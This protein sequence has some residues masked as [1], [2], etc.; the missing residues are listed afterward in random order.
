MKVRPADPFV[1][2]EIDAAPIWSADDPRLEPIFL[3]GPLW[4]EFD[5]S[6]RREPD[7]LPWL[8]DTRLVVEFVDVAPLDPARA[9]F[10]LEAARSPR[11]SAA[12]SA[13]G[14]GGSLAVHLLVFAV[15][16]SR[17]SAPAETGA[18]IPVQLVVEAPKA[19]APPPEAPPA[20]VPQT[21]P[22]EQ[23]SAVAAPPRPPTPAAAPQPKR[24]PPKSAPP[25][26]AAASPPQRRLLP[27]Q[28]TEPAVL[29]PGPDL[30]RTDYFAQLV[31]L[32][33]PHLGLLPPSFLAG[34]RGTTTLA[35][36]VDSDGTIERIAIKRSS[37]YPD[38]DTQIERVIVAVGRFPPLPPAYDGR[39]VELDFDL[40]F[41]DAMNGQ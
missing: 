18:P 14:F 38:I 5:D 1:E 35:I 24:A 37:G 9:D 3:P 40:R 25:R 22:P 20:E 8:K 34:R 30:T 21:P 31:A 29:R 4:I 2:F 26:Q 17:S 7:P 16:L 13:R 10:A 28:Q 36:L 12:A 11:S 41:P 32:T 19:G 27:P 33:R 6:D 15:F 23:P 39:S